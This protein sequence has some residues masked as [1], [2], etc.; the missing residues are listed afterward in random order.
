MGLHK[1]KMGKRRNKITYSL[2]FLE[3]IYDELCATPELNK[4]EIKI[5]NSLGIMI[6]CL[7]AHKKIEV[8]PDSLLIEL[9]D[10]EAFI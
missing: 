3:G 7:K 10:A 4:N 1:T 2:E 5:F 6:P 9:L 8:E